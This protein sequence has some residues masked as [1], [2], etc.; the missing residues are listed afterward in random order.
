MLIDSN[1]NKFN[2]KETPYFNLYCFK[3]QKDK[4]KIF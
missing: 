4:V 3:N 2:L 1:I